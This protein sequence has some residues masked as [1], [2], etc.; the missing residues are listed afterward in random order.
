VKAVVTAKDSVE[1]SEWAKVN[2]TDGLRSSAHPGIQLQG[3]V[4]D[5]KPSATIQLRKEF[6]LDK[7]IKHAVAY[8][9]GLGFYELSC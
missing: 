8:V 9:C 7:Q 2:L 1:T 6:A 5:L 3:E 4:A